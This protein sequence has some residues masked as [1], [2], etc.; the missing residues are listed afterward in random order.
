MADVVQIKIQR[1]L[2]Y[3]RENTV[4]LIHPFDLLINWQIFMALLCLWR[5]GG[6]KDVS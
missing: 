1:I 5:C 4:R 3:S 6:Y 2:H